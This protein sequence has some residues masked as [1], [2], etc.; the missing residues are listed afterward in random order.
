MRHVIP[1][2]ILV[3]V[4]IGCAQNVEEEK[5]IEEETNHEIQEG[6]EKEQIEKIEQ[7]ESAELSIES[8]FEEGEKIPQKYTCDG[9]DLSPPI[10]IEGIPEEAKTLAMIVDDPDAPMGV[11]THWVIWNIPADETVN[12]AE[13]VPKV[14]ELTEPIHALQGINDF[15]KIGYNGPA[16]LQVNIDTGSRFTYSTLY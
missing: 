5:Q 2:L 13:G 1:A 8:V 15:K 16:P 9:Q 3:C 12:L 11:F 14:S 6:A 4:L 7:V 10:K